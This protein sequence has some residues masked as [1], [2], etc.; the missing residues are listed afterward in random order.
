MLKIYSFAN[1]YFNDWCGK[2]ELVSKSQLAFYSYFLTNNQMM[3]T[4]HNQR[5]FES[6]TSKRIS[7]N[8]VLQP[9]FVL[10]ISFMTLNVSAQTITV[11]EAKGWFETA[12]VKWSPVENAESYNVY[13]SGNGYTNQKI[14]DQLIRSYGSYIRADI[15]GLAAGSYTLKIAAVIDGVEA[16]SVST[17]SVT[18]MAHDRTGF[19]FSGN[20]VPGA[21]KADGTPK[22]GAVI[23]YITENTKNTISMD[24]TGATSNPCVG[25]QTILD[26]FKKGKD[27]RPLIVRFVGQITDMSYM[28]NGDIVV[29]NSNNA[30]GYITLEGI[31]D[32]AVADGWGIRIKNATNVEVR[33]MGTMNCDSGEG[34]NIGLQQGNDHIWVHHCDF[35]YG[36]AGGDADQ[37]KGDGALDCKKS[38]YVTFSYNHFWDNGKCNLLGLSE[39][40]TS[41]L[42]ITYHHNWYDHSDSRHPRV[43]FYSAHVYNNYYDGNAKYGIGSTKGS[44]VFAEGNY[45]RNCKYPMLI[46]MQGSDV[47]DES[48][49]ANDYSD[50][51][52][53]SKE[54]GGIIKAYNNYM[55]GQKRFVAYGDAS[56]SGSNADFDAVVVSS[57]SQTV[58]SSVSSVYGGNSYNNFDNS[59]AMYAYT[60]D[61]PETAKTKV[62]AYAGRM[63][64]GDF[65]WT[66]DNST[67]DTDYAVNTALKSALSSYNTTLV[68][69]QGE[70][71]SSTGT[72]EDPNTGGDDNTGT[73]ITGDVVHN[74]TASGASS[75]FF[76][77]TGNLSTS[78]G[79]VTYGDL[80]LTQCLKLESSTSI[81]FTTSEES[82]L[83][84]V[85]N[86]T[87]SG[88]IYIDG[89]SYTATSGILSVTLA[90]GS[91]TIT[92]GD[93][94][95]LYL[96]SITYSSTEEETTTATLTKGGSGSSSQSI[97]LGNAIVDFYYTF[98]D[99]T[100]AI[101]SGLPEGVTATVD[102]S[103]LTITISGTPTVAGT[104]T[105]TI[106]TDGADVNASV[107]G[108][109]TVNEVED[110]IATLTKGG[111]GSSSQSI[112]LG[113][114]IVDF[115]YTFTDAT[116]VT[117]TGLPDGVTATVD[118]SALTITISGTPTTA[119]TYAYTITT[120][121]AD[122]NVSVTGTITVNEVEEP[123][124]A[125]IIQENTTGFCSVEGTIDS[126]NDGY[127][128]DGFANTSNGVG[129]GIDWYLLADGGTYTLT[130]RYA[131]GASS[132]R[133]ADLIINGE[134]V[135]HISFAAT[136]DWTTWTTVSVSIDL[137]YNVYD[138][139]LEADTDGGL[140]NI[141]YISVSGDAF[142]IVE[143]GTVL[144]DS[145]SSGNETI[146][147]EDVV[148]NFTES[149]ATSDFFAISGNLSTSKG[150]VT[151]DGLTLTQCLKMESSTSV[152]FTTTESGQLTLV[153]NETFAGDVNIDGTAYTVSAGVLSVDIAAGSHT[154]TKAD[155]ANLYYISIAYGSTLK[156]A[157]SLGKVSGVSVKMYPNPVV[158]ELFV[159][160]S[161]NIVSVAVYNIGGTLVQKQMSV[162]GSVDMSQ[163]PAGTYVVVVTT[164]EGVYQQKVIK[165]AL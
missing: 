102:A 107:S 47:Y 13:Y 154:I 42:Y 7:L 46:S 61:A 73:E 82:E 15:P 127:T 145:S 110:T 113:D 68:A 164:Q 81:S 72:G 152:S 129:Y 114:A 25:L 90:D 120:E 112:D 104:Y 57:Q 86:D 97:D 27:T 5:F 74:F 149:G 150:T 58:S 56:Y 119:G 155:V 132:D 1:R 138:I 6:K 93:S 29:E 147:S 53:F 2:R 63:D 151:Y 99:A 21:Y 105:Y 28:L 8:Y 31:G 22:S 23:L 75:S 39:G 160:S 92:K 157:S 89:T 45:F 76:S 50:M 141:D 11:N 85:F 70:S 162:N 37:A 55:T 84:L 30:S 96:M 159:T 69:V 144:D 128:G 79:T 130:W 51:P 137:D 33:N 139:R 116:G 133:S 65:K 123:T 115:Y 34:D 26:G 38:T 124:T 64:G 54:D 131:N 62:M 52:T 163:L 3:T 49:G 71:N 109:I 121:G 165:K 67:D 122:V 60:A 18:V 32:D 108:T 41:G 98:T 95:N 117:V 106:T 143:C 156:G 83:V 118:A 48:A 101:A 148:H 35:F 24:V 10:L 135:N 17:S 103:A 100:S 126:N 44:S 59:S 43:R 78:K 88:S 12:V 20:R 161:A 91:H 134:V 142:S 136:T 87:F 146:T 9:L 111:V 40:T 4:Q 125:T 14:D 16:T 36:D 94:A 140:A 66:F 19:A 158:N 80:T 77:I 153:F